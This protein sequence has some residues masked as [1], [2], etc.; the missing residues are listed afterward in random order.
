M[1]VM[2][3]VFVLIVALVLAAPLLSH[4]APATSVKIPT[5]MKRGALSDDLAGLQGTLTIG[6]YR[7]E[8]PDRL[9][10]IAAY[11]RDSGRQI[12]LVHWFALWGGW[13]RAFNRA[14]L[15]RVEASSAV[16]L[17]SWE[18]WSGQ[19]ADP[20]W[21]LETINSGQ[22]DPYIRSWGQG[23]AAYGKP[24][25]LRFA[26]EM[27]ATQY[28]WATGVNGNPAF[29]YVSAWRRVQAIFADAGATNV[30]WV[31]S[32]NNPGGETADQLIAT[33]RSLFPGDDAVDYLGIG[34]YNTGPA[35]DWGAPR[36]RTFDD[37][38]D[39]AYRALT[40]ISTK[41]IVIAEVGSTETGGDK[42]DWIDEAMRAEL[43]QRFPR[44]R[45]LVW[46]DVDNE[47]RWQR[48]SST[49]AYLSFIDGVRRIGADGPG[50]LLLP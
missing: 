8:L 21:S 14:D 47:Q 27:H 38:L 30:R 45:A 32:P 39:P 20:R 40:A 12:G 19:M 48:G 50:D 42:G 13:K 5:A 9:D 33:Y 4:A 7:P 41:P 1:V 43:R 34:V 29:D 18:P 37:A 15:D 25:L 24:V 44:V 10:A 49:D 22:H 35:L 28:P 16:A 6:V 23:L 46:F 26:H 17:I 2:R 11:E 3:R 36:W 31:W